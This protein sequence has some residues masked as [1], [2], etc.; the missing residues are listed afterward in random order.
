MKT[1]LLITA[2]YDPAADLLLAE[3]RR[4]DVPAVR[5][6][7]HEF[8][9]ESTL[10]YRASHHGFEAVIGSDGRSVDFG[11]VGSI[12]WQWDQPGGFPDSLSLAEKRF[13]ERQCQLAL[14]ALISMGRVVWINHPVSE[15]LACSKPAQLFVARNVGLEIPR[16]VITNDPEE[17]R[18]FMSAAPA[19]TVHKALSPPRG[20]DRKKVLYTSILTDEA[21]ANLDLIR[22][23]PAI[24]QDRVD[25]AYELRITVVGDSIFAARIDSQANPNAK[26]DWRR[27][28]HDV[29]YQAV[30]LPDKIEA[31]IR[32][33]MQELGLVYGALD[34]IVT[35]D[36]RYVFLEVNP[37]GAYMWV[38][39]A[40][41]Q[42]ITGAL[43]DLLIEACKP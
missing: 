5:W 37:S 16:T 1:V 30:E 21:A 10:T 23:T 11:T 42:N 26:L 29:D 6:N 32:A 3:L 4:R 7:T 31:S 35:P 28:Q 19:Q 2:R 12:W 8:P 33:L 41:G 40:T 25:K 36:Q 38:E 20:L 17:V 14:D 39:N 24:F 18:R 27:S 34:F 9:L 22:I 13:A 15:R 43:A